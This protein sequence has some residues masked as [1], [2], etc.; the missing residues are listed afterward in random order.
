MSERPQPVTAQKQNRPLSLPS[1]QIPL[2]EPSLQHK[3]GLVHFLPGYL[4]TL[5]LHDQRDSSSFSKIRPSAGGKF[6]PQPAAK[7]SW[8]V[9]LLKKMKNTEHSTSAHGF[10]HSPSN[11]AKILLVLLGG[12]GNG[13]RGPDWNPSP[14]SQ[15]PGL[16]H[17]PRMFL[18]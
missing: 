2:K 1:D 15:C 13:Q 4:R 6:L 8:Q 14:R 10:I 3:K 17:C 7:G 16:I 9:I 12:G 11:S 18:K 5:H